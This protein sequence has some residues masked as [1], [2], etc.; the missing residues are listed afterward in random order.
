MPLTDR[1]VW[2]ISILVRPIQF[3]PNPH[4]IC[5]PSVLWN[6]GMTYVMAVLQ[7]RWLSA[8]KLCDYGGSRFLSHGCLG[9]SKTLTQSVHVGGSV[10]HTSVLQT[11]HVGT[12]AS[13]N[14]RT[15]G[16]LGAALSNP[17]VHMTRSPPRFHVGPSEKGRVRRAAVAFHLQTFRLQLTL[18]LSL[19]QYRGLLLGGWVCY[20]WKGIESVSIV[21]KGIDSI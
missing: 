3:N 21:W 15:F 20:C 7:P 5:Q 19:G 4:L 12:S 8:E 14:R 17:F 10:E 13:E 18:S 9:S 11:S 6:T 1:D 16:S 2:V